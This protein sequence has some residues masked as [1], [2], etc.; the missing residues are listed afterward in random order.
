[1]I[2]KKEHCEQIHTHVEETY[3]CSV[4]PKMFIVR[5]V[6]MS[7]IM[8]T[9]LFALQPAGTSI[10]YTCISVRVLL[11]ACMCLCVCTRTARD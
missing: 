7:K 1:M 6:Y 3:I 5:T 11:R 9:R 8:I 10:F 4:E 2:K